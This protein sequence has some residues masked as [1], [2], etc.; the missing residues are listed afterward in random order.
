MM[1]AS[2]YQDLS[3]IRHCSKHFAYSNLINF[4][5]VPS[6]AS[7]PE[8][9]GQ[10]W[11]SQRDSLS[12]PGWGGLAQTPPQGAPSTNTLSTPSTFPGQGPQA[13]ALLW[14]NLQTRCF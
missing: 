3:H 1:V 9:L 2:I 5:C 6:E 7:L 14:S 12:V 13:L 11:G 4:C 10:P 8:T